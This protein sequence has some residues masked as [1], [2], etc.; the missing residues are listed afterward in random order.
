MT[1]GRKAVV[2]G[3]VREAHEAYC[4]AIQADPHNGSAQ[5]E[6][7]RL[8]LIQRDAK[9]GLRQVRTAL[10]L[11]PDSRVLQGLLGDALARLGRNEPARRAWLLEAQLDGGDADKAL[12]ATYLRAARQ[13]KN[14]HTWAG[15][16]RYYRRV[17]VFDPSN[18]EASLG[19]ARAL[20]GLGELD[21]ARRWTAYAA[22]LSQRNPEVTQLAR[23]LGTGP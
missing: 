22:K 6:L 14:R 7:A 9:A 17:A 13:F 5:S 20:H 18:L 10:E 16:E 4:R 15:A 19:I 23:E 1:R 2:R 21:E 11:D 3:D 8:L 12:V